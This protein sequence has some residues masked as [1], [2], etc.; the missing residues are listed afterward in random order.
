[1]P[2]SGQNRGCRGEHLAGALPPRTGLL[3]PVSGV[4]RPGSAG[5]AVVGTAPPA[6]VGRAGP[7]RGR[8]RDVSVCCAASSRRPTRG[9]EAAGELLDLPERPTAL[10]VFNDRTGAGALRAAH[11]RRL[12]VPGVRPIPLPT[13]TVGRQPMPIGI[14]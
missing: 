2:R 11:E 10:I 7:G 3:R 13:G 8:R 9:R 1:M 5:T 4:S 14:G 6:D 12:R